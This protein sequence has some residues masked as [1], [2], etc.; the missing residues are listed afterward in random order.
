MQLLN[1]MKANTGCKLQATSRKQIQPKAESLKLK[2]NTLLR[3][4]RKPSRPGTNLET[5]Q[6][7]TG[8]R[9]TGGREQ[10]T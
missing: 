5:W 6:Q 2:A 1:R 4:N 8:N 9:Q 7:V 3:G 10:R